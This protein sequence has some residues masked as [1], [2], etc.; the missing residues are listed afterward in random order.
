M[1]I[2]DD[3]DCNR[4]K[5]SIVTLLKFE[6]DG[7]LAERRLLWGTVYLSSAFHML[8][9]I[10]RFTAY[11]KQQSRGLRRNCVWKSDT[12]IGLEVR[13]IWT[14]LKTEGTDETKILLKAASRLRMMSF[15]SN[16]P[17]PCQITFIIIQMAM[18][19]QYFAR[20]FMVL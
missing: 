8:A 10:T 15:E 3:E 14:D 1:G 16:P 5:Q 13:E 6:L 18:K 17:P 9:G 20:E 4:D 11:R 7:W 2:G 19:S 12:A